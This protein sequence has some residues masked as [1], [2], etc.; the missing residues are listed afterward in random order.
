MSSEN[1]SALPLV[2]FTVDG[3]SYEF[4]PSAYNPGLPVDPTREE[5]NVQFKDA[6]SRYN[7]LGY[8]I[9]KLKRQQ[10]YA[11]LDA[12]A[13]YGK[14]YGDIKGFEYANQNN[15]KSPTEAA[16]NA[17]LSNDDAVIDSNKIAIDYQQLVDHLFVFQRTV[18][19]TIE[20]IK[21]ASKLYL[22]DAKQE[23]L[24]KLN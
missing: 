5:I 3:I 4:D 20:Q 7:L 18:E 23:R 21:E 10:K 22:T 12:E 6:I 8:C 19:F 14:R 11:Q 1:K 16:L 24:N 13:I 9:S 2:R 15:G 17:A